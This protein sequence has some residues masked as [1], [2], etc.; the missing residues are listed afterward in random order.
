[1]IAKKINHRVDDNNIRYDKV[2]I[3]LEGNLNSK[4]HSVG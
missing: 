1:M 2:N 4:P 3:K